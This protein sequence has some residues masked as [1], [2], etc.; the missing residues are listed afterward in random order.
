VN[1]PAAT[2]NVRKNQSK[3]A[4]FEANGTATRHSAGAGFNPINR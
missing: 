2:K 4:H 1:Q 3:C